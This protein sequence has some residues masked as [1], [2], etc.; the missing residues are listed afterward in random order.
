MGFWEAYELSI[1]AV[2]NGHK[3]RRFKITEIYYFRFCESEVQ[4]ESTEC[5]A[6]GPTRP[7]SGCGPAW[8][9]LWRLGGDSTSGSFG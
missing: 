5:S 4:V 3:F 9:L 7:K 6:Q 1:A 2:T 8:A